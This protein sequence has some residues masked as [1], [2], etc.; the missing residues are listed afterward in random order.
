MWC[1]FHVI[2]MF[3]ICL[4]TAELRTS[5]SLSGMVD[6]S[7]HAPAELVSQVVEVSEWLRAWLYT[8]GVLADPGMHGENVN[9]QNTPCVEFML[10]S[11]DNL[12]VAYERLHIAGIWH[13]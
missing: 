6:D 1:W 5:E 8:R 7:L 2:I 13:S 4:Q 10:L 12:C 9:G 11:S 3:V